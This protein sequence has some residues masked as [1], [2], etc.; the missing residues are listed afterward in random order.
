MQSTIDAA[1]KKVR[2]GENLT[3]K[4]IKKVKSVYKKVVLAGKIVGYTEASELLS[5]YISP[6]KASKYSEENP[7]IIDS[8]VYSSSAIVQYAIQEMT[9]YICNN[10]D[11]TNGGEQ[12]YSGADILSPTR[13]NSYTE[14]NVLKNGYLIAEQNNLRLKS[15]DHRFNLQATAILDNSGNLNIMWNVTSLYD[16]DP[17]TRNS[18][19]DSTRVTKLSYEGLSLTIEDGLSS[20]LDKIGAAQNFY[21]EAKWGYTK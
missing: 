15:T 8:D 19:I 14:G 16:F 5:T 3:E 20:Y 11:Y 6:K 17:Y 10:Y 2:N 1:E 21:S 18:A 12:E 4:E 9:A 13:R 7:L